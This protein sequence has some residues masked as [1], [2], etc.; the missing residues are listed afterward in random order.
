[1]RSHS[2]VQTELCPAGS[3][4]HSWLQNKPDPRVNVGHR[5]HSS[6]YVVLKMAAEVKQALE[7]KEAPMTHVTQTNGQTA[8][9]RPL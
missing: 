7:P 4:I 5:T 6:S 1:M 9:I 2:Q 3:N 8:F